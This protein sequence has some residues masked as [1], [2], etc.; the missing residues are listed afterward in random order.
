[1]LIDQYSIH[2][3][4]EAAV[5]DPKQEVDTILHL[6]EE[7]HFKPQRLGEDFCARAKLC[8]EWVRRDKSYEAIGIDI[9]DYLVKS[10]NVRFGVEGVEHRATA[11]ARDVLAYSD[12]FKPVDLVHAGNFSWFYML[13]R[14][15][16]YRYLRSVKSRLRPGGVFMLDHFGG[17]GTACDGR[18]DSKKSGEW[19]PITGIPGYFRFECLHFNPATHYCVYTID[20]LMDDGSHKLGAFTYHWRHWSLP[21][22]REAMHEVGFYNIRTFF[23]VSEEDEDSRYE[24]VEHPYPS[25]VHSAYVVGVV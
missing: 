6:C 12:D 1:M 18:A 19:L 25:E 24:E 10:A 5:Q 11:M 23:D 14:D 20:F 16:L 9:D 4:Y 3:L 2:D 17:Y 22:I 8:S 21:E 7:M 15:E 13:T